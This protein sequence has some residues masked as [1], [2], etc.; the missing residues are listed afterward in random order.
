MGSWQLRM[1]GHGMPC[2][3]GGTIRASRFEFD[4][5][6]GSVIQIRRHQTN[7][8]IARSAGCPCLAT[9]LSGLATETGATP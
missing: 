4:A 6:R 7:Q 2:P 5:D 9:K 8:R 1:V 3:Y